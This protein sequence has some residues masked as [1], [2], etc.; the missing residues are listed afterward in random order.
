[1]IAKVLDASAFAAIVFLETKLSAV[2][3]RLRDSELHAP[4]LLHFEMANVCVKKIR[5]RPHERDIILR[6]HAASFGVPILLHDVDYAET[7]L[8]SEH[9]SLTAY[10][11]SYLWLARALGVELVTLDVDL[12]K[13][14]AKI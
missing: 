14:A 2:Q 5:A 3:A 8:L 13:A 9:H 6:Q 10:D 11:A 12:E 7:V 1:V 4:A